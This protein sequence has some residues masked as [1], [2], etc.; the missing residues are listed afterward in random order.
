MLNS[1]MLTMPSETQTTSID[2]ASAGGLFNMA[3]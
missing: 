3:N 1:Q 2:H